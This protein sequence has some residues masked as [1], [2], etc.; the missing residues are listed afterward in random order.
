VQR[1]LKKLTS[2]NIIKITRSAP[3]D[4]DALCDF[5][6]QSEWVSLERESEFERKMGDFFRRERLES[7][8]DEPLFGVLESP[9]PVVDAC[10]EATIPY[11][12]EFNRLGE[13]KKHDKKGKEH[14]S[15]RPGV[16]PKKGEEGWEILY[17]ALRSICHFPIDCSERQ[18][19]IL[20]RELE[21]FVS[22]HPGVDADQVTGFGIWWENVAGR[23]FA[24]MP[25]HVLDN[26][27]R[28][29]R[30][31]LLP[32]RAHMASDENYE[33]MAEE[34]RRLTEEDPNARIIL[35]RRK[36]EDQKRGLIGVGFKESELPTL[37]LDEEEYY[38]V[39]KAAGKD[40]ILGQLGDIHDYLPSLPLES[41]ERKDSVDHDI[42]LVEY[43][44]WLREATV[45]Q[46]R[47][48]EEGG[49]DGEK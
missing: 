43:D 34:T 37:P 27:Q 36:S 33:K 46:S 14:E 24:P 25:T 22:R 44:E 1:E 29:D 2:Y 9:S 5:V 13:L 11:N 30:E 48:T 47:G 39:L 28:Y 26:W 7:H 42:S 4:Y 49:G 20:E 16:R 23:K 15:E 35:L 17:H 38:S 40:F 41:T 8:K 32:K 31:V 12:K 21:L 18:K 10:S 3:V 6:A 45:G 19:R